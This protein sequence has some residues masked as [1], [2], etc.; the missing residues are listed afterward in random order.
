LRTATFFAPPDLL[1]MPHSYFA[2]CDRA[3][4]RDAE[5]TELADFEA[6]REEGL[7]R[8]GAGYKQPDRLAIDVRD[9]IG[10]ILLAVSLSFQVE[11]R[12]C[13]TLCLVST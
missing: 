8:G 11:P 1:D 7:V 5:G 4:L 13:A 6:A 3:S 10:R 2:L 12:V 9:E